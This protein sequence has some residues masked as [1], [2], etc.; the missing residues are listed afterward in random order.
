MFSK[1]AGSSVRPHSLCP[2]HDVDAEEAVDVDDEG[3][4][5]QQDVVLERESEGDDAQ[6]DTVHQRLAARHYLP[7]DDE[8]QK[9][10]VT[11][12]PHK[13]WCVHC[14]AGRTPALS[15]NRKPNVAG[16]VSELHLDYAFLSPDGVEVPSHECPILVAKFKPDGAIYARQVPE[17]GVGNPY[18]VDILGDICEHAGFRQGIIKSDDES[19]LVAVVNKFIENKP[20]MRHLTS[21]ENQHESNG[22]AER[23]VKTI[24]E[25]S[26]VLVSSLQARCGKVISPSLLCLVG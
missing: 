22:V 11:H 7:S 1:A 4:A 14:V 25:T 5:P 3:S 10:I 17:K 8:I 26:R 19:S 2:L 15:H 18:T 24:Q 16:T 9:H 12:Y 13:A 23:A 6:D 21:P 20:N